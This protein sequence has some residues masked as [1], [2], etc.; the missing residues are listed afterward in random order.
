MSYRICNIFSDVVLS[1]FQSKKNDDESLGAVRVWFIP[2][3]IF[4][5]Q[6]TL[7]FKY[8]IILQNKSQERAVRVCVRAR[9]LS[10]FLFLYAIPDNV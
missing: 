2:L 7:P 6:R 9:L 8:M 5:I 4:N 3:K 1:L 10:F